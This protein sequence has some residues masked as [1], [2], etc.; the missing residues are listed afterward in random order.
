[1]DNVDVSFILP[2]RKLISLTFDD[3]PAKTAERILAV[4]AEFNETHPQNKA[5]ATFFCN[6]RL[7]TPHAIPTLHAAHATG[8]ELGNHTQNHLDLTTLSPEQLQREIDET[9]KIL[10]KIDNQPRH[11]LRAPY[12]KLSEEVRAAAYTPIIDWTID[13]QDWTGVSA[14]EIFTTVMKEKYSG[15]IVLM[16][17]GYDQTVEALKRLLPALDE[18]GYQAVSVSQMAKAHGCTL[19]VGGVYVRARKG[20]GA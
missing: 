9:D 5:T 19:R 17:D 10:R 18:A 20:K 6:G 16:H 8:M 7:C 11:L 12:G 4:F 13:T 3:A 2:Q 15:A 1:V 14:D